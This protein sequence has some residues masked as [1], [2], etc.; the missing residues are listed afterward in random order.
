[1]LKA[2]DAPKGDKIVIVKTY[3]EGKAVMDVKA[4]TTPVSAYT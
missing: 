2:Y 3:D 4:A 1:M